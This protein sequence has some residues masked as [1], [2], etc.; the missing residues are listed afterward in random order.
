MIC[1]RDSMADGFLVKIIFIKKELKIFE[2]TE[3]PQ[4]PVS[5]LL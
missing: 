1:A 5:F 4:N 2:E 3:Y